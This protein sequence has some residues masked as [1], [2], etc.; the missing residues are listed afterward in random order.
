MKFRSVLSL[1]LII[2]FVGSSWG[3]EP[4]I[5][6]L[7][8]EI[9]RLE[10]ENVQLRKQ[11]SQLK[12]VA[13]RAARNDAAWKVRSAISLYYA[14]GAVDGIPS[15]PNSISKDIFED[16]VVPKSNFGGYTWSYD[17]ANGYVTT[18]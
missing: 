6:D 16:G 11:I 7:K 13:N 5:E 8:K 4:T 17:S 2:A 1:F 9:K 3:Q 12:D 14:K 10:L 15:W 18:N